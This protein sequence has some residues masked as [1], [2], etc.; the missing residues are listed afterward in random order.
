MFTRRTRPLPA[1]PRCVH[2]TRASAQDWKAKYPELTFAVIPAENASGVT[3]RYAP[4]M[5]IS[6]RNSA[7][8]SSCASPTTTLR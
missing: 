3:E 5:T 7:S 2:R 6:P 8:R 4:F 1:P